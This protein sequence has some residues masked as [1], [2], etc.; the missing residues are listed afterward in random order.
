MALPKQLALEDIWLLGSYQLSSESAS[1]LCKRALS[2]RDLYL[3]SFYSDTNVA[4]ESCDSST[5][6]EFTQCP[7]LE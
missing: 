4:G 2:C 5:N 6:K 7:S 3:T 1:I